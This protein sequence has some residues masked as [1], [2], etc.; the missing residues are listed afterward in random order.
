VSTAQESKHRSERERSNT[1]AQAWQS[2]QERPNTRDGKRERAIT[3]D[4]DRD[5]GR[6][7]DGVREHLDPGESIDLE[8]AD[9]RCLFNAYIG[10][11]WLSEGEHDHRRVGHLA[12]CRKVCSKV[13]SIIVVPA[14]RRV[15]GLLAGAR[16][17]IIGRRLRPVQYVSRSGRQGPL[18][19]VAPC[20]CSST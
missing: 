13:S 5:R 16:A 19:K 12:T 14:R 9:Q 15:G 7:R 1:T 4:R 11:G 3:R 17:T 6:E 20:L 10:G 2:K 8:P 18:W